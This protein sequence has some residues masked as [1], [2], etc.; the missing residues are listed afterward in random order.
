VGINRSPQKAVFRLVFYVKVV[1]AKCFVA[2][3]L[4]PELVFD[5]HTS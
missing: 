4:V 1:M 3:S 5:I 2:C